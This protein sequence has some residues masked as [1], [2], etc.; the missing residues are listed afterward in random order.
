[1]SIKSITLLAALTLSAL[2]ASAQNELNGRVTDKKGNPIAGAK[3]ENSKTSEQTTT[4]MNGQFSLQTAQP[5]KRINVEYMGLKPVSKKKARQDM[6]VKMSSNLDKGHFFFAFQN[7]YTA[8]YNAFG[9]MTGYVKNWGGYVSY[10][11][12]TD[13]EEFYTVTAGVMHRLCGKLFA[14][15]GLGVN[16]SEK[17]ERF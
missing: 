9:I 3:V 4:D 8:H 16:T 14:Y 5:V 12:D 1:M 11:A 15:G 17:V 13:E 7:A 10:V 6:T 2:T